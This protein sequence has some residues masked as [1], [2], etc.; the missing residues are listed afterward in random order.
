MNNILVNEDGSP[1]F[2]ARLYLV[3]HE[4]M[5]AG[6]YSDALATLTS[7]AMLKPGFLGF[8]FDLD[9]N[10][11]T[12]RIAYFDTHDALQTWLSESSVLFPYGVSLEDIV[13][14]TGCLWPWL[15]DEET[16]EK[17]YMSGTY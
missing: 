1:P 9:D 4:S 13:N 10:G 17:S 11:N 5:D 14:G 16:E 6:Q 12:L 15:G 7:V 2:Y 8:N 3:A